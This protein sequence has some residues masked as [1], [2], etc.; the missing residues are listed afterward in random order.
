MS[1]AEGTTSV[2]LA[3]CAQQ[4]GPC[5]ADTDAPSPQ[6]SIVQD[7]GAA[8]RT[9]AHGAEMARATARATVKVRFRILVIESLL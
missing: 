2:W 1:D 3:G 7:E 9:E 5:G 4:Q 6:P 8:A